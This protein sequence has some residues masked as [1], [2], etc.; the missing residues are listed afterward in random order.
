MPGRRRASRPSPGRGPATARAR[1]PPSHIPGSSRAGRDGPGG[2]ADHG[3]AGPGAGGGAGGGGGGG[4]EGEAG[5]AFR[6]QH[7][8]CN[9]K[10]ECSGSPV[11]LEYRQSTAPPGPGARDPDPAAAWL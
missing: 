3:G 9:L 2:V 8:G 4:G 7:S 10:A 11:Q 1:S 5:S 6:L